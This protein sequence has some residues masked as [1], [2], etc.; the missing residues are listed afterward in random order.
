MLHCS[1]YFCPKMWKLNCFWGK[2][3]LKVYS[4]SDIS[5]KSDRRE[6]VQ[7]R[8]ANTPESDIS[9]KSDA[10]VAM[11]KLAQITRF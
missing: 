2:I 10:N 9:M 7:R 3:E 11:R 5:M 6:D 8:Q 1:T 4:E